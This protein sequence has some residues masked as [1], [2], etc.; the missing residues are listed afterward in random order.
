MKKSKKKTYKGSSEKKKPL[1]LEIIKAAAR[2]EEWAMKTIL[3][4]YDAY[5]NRLARRELFDCYGNPIVCMDYVFKE[6]LQS[7][8]LEGVMSFKIRE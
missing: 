6:E 8:L 3:K 5:I 7:K 2:G 1:N 4:Y